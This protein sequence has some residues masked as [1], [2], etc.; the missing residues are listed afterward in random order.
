MILSHLGLPT[1]LPNP[2]PARAPPW[3][4]DE[5]ALKDDVELEPDVEIDTGQD[6]EVVQDLADLP[7]H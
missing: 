6:M 7:D 3:T 4:D 5:L 2:A 1:T